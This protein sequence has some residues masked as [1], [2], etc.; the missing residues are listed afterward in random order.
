MIVKGK[1]RNDAINIAK[2]ALKEFH[3]GGVDS[4]TS[5]HQYMLKNEVFLSGDYTLDFIDNLIAEGCSFDPSSEWN[6]YTLDS[7]SENLKNIFKIRKVR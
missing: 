3:I 7:F 6:M 4:T 2:R 1:D 5:F